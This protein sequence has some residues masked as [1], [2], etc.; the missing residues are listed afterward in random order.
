MKKR[1]TFRNLISVASVICV[2]FA[3]SGIGYAGF[4]AQ[5][6]GRYFRTYTGSLQ[7]REIVALVAYGQCPGMNS[8]INPYKLDG[9]AKIENYISKNRVE[10]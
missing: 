8:G 4:K 1:M 7:P 9:K 5:F 2:A 3:F 10:E 6:S